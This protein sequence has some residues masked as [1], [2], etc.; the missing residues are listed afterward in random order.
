MKIEIKCKASNQTVFCDFPAMVLIN[1][2]YSPLH[3]H[4][5]ALF[6]MCAG[7]QRF[8]FLFLA[9]FSWILNWLHLCFT[10][11]ATHFQLQPCVGPPWKRTIYTEFL[12]R[13]SSFTS[14]STYSEKK[15]KALLKQIYKSNIC[16]SREKKRSREYKHFGI[17]S[18]DVSVFLLLISFWLIQVEPDGFCI[19]Q[20]ATVTIN[21][22]LI[23]KCWL[24]HS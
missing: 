13:F 22:R 9:L 15:R 16:K 3:T 23:L 19:C 7:L 17:S 12:I 4:I 10:F 21:S 24:T 11:F 6:W 5:C 20:L 18:L 14:A 8:Y 1:F 2:S